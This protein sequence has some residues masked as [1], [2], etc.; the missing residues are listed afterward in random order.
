MRRRSGSR[1]SRIIGA[2]RLGG[3]VTT[4][5]VSEGDAL[6]HADRIRALDAK[7]DGRLLNMLASPDVS[8]M[9]G[10]EILRFVA[11]STWDDEDTIEL[12]FASLK[13]DLDFK[14]GVLDEVMRLADTEGVP[15]TIALSMMLKSKRYHTNKPTPFTINKEGL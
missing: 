15:P 8:W 3:E 14:L 5:N 6:A 1:L 11:K 4:I 9:A 7:T 13:S 10:I 12:A 2:I